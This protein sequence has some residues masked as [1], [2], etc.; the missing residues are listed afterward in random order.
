MNLRKVLQWLLGHPLFFVLERPL[1]IES[2]SIGIETVSWC[3]MT[4]SMLWKYNT[5][6]RSLQ[7]FKQFC[8]SRDFKTRIWLASRHFVH[9]QK[10]TAQVKWSASAPHSNYCYCTIPVLL[11]QIILLIPKQT[12][13]SK[14]IQDSMIH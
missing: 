13:E 3:N 6:E 5:F 7:G 10:V 8:Q 9:S 2:L 1:H 12:S 11:K 4:R 14:R